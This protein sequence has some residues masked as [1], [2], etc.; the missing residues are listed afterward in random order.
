MH[1]VS[2]QE[3]DCG[4]LR[5]LLRQIEQAPITAVDGGDRPQID[6]V[7]VCIHVIHVTCTVC[8]WGFRAACLE[9]LLQVEHHVRM[10]HSGLCHNIKSMI[11]IYVNMY[12]IFT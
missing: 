5:Q 7:W 2:L 6:P 12:T 11:K 8:R 4:N 9:L 3:E 1:L 10:Q